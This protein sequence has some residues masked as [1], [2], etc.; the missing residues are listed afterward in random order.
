MKELFLTKVTSNKVPKQAK[1]NSNQKA[2]F[3]MVTSW[4]VNSKAKVLI[5][6]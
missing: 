3:T 4:M 2:M 6:L 5:I 1:E